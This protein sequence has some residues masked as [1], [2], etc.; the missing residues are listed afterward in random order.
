MFCKSAQ[1]KFSDLLCLN[2]KSGLIFEEDLELV[3]V[4]F[5]IFFLNLKLI[6][7][8]IKNIVDEV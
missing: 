3:C 7:N 6:A 1:I 5:V 8:K 4:F 2:S